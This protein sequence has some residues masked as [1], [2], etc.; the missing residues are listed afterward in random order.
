MLLK[1][2]G[3]FI[4]P[5]YLTKQGKINNVLLSQ[6]ITLDLIILQCLIHSGIVTVNVHPFPGVVC[7]S[8]VPL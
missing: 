3:C 6:T 7:M 1:T 2:T 4:S 5:A 8:A